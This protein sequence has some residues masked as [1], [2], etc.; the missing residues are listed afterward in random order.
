MRVRCGRAVAGREKSRLPDVEAWAWHP[1]FVRY[2]ARDLNK[3]FLRV[4][5]VAMDDDAWAGWAAI[6]MVAEGVITDAEH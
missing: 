6:R 3:R 2:A 1:K 5:G 4:Q